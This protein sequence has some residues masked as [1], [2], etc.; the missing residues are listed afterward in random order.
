[1]MCQNSRGRQNERLSH[2][3]PCQFASI[4]AGLATCAAAQG[5]YIALWGVVL[6]ST[7]FI[8]IQLFIVG[9][10]MVFYP[11]HFVWLQQKLGLTISQCEPVKPMF[12]LY[13]IRIMGVA[14]WVLIIVVFTQDG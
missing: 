2:I 10:W 4:G 3:N 5:R 1:M 6:S 9:G 14:N 7:V 8:A 12:N 11:Q 13:A